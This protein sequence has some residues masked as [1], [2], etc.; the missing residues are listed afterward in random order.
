MNIC[1]QTKDQHKILIFTMS[2]W[3][4][5]GSLHMCMY[6]VH[7]YSAVVDFQLLS[8]LLKSKRDRSIFSVVVS[9]F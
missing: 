9:Q 7:L 5:K 8:A 6:I 1:L 2:V 3:S 4:D